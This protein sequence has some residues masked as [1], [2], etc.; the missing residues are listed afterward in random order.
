MVFKHIVDAN[1]FAPKNM[2]DLDP[3]LLEQT[4]V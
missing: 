2:T 3:G 1:N 4:F